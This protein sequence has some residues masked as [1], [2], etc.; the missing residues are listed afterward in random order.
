MNIPQIE[1]GLKDKFGFKATIGASTLT[2]PGDPIKAI[3]E[4]LEAEIGLSRFEITL[5]KP[6]ENREE[7]IREL[8]NLSQEEG[9]EYSAH[10]PFLY[11]D[12][13]HP[14]PG[15]RGVYVDEAKRTIDLAAEIG[16]NRVVVHPGDRF[17]DSILP[18]NETL[19]SLKVPRESYLRNSRESL[20]TLGKYAG[21]R[22]VTLL[23]ENLASGLCDLKEEMRETLASTPNSEF[24]LDIGHANV[25]GTMDGLMKLEPRYFHFHDNNGE[26]DSHLELGAGTIELNRLI[27]KASEYNSQ[28]TLIF[29][30]YSVNALRKS[31]KSLERAL[32]AQRPG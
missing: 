4:F 31:L 8:K 19:E 10:V 27:R 29:E 23:I 13:S 32:E 26:E 2:Y 20:Q 6:L 30:L 25:S 18:P 14:H 28:K 15:I 16:A 11:D 12:I 9:L 17:F 24:L 1:K 3:N 7:T 21:S 22:G 5:G